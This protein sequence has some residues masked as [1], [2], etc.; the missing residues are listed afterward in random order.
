MV[1][2]PIKPLPGAENAGKPGYYTVKAGDT[3]IRI[4]LENGQG[5]KDI[6]RWNNLDNANLIEVGQE[7]RIRPPESGA[8]ARPIN[9]NS[10]VEVRPVTPV[11]SAP[12]AAP[13][14][15]SSTSR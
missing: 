8:V 13:P 3:L 1:V 12:A 6:A 11:A 2:T 14:S 4:G 7:L 9:T 10:G 5:W 15:A